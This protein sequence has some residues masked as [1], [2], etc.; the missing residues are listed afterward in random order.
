MTETRTP[1]TEVLIAREEHA[2]ILAGFFRS[3]WDPR[4]TAKGVLASRE[5][6]AR[7]NPAARGVPPPTFLVVAEGKCIGFVTTIPGMIWA[8]G[9]EVQ[10]YWLKGL[11]VLPEFRNGPVGFLLLKEAVRH[12][13]GYLFGMA[14][15][16]AARKL[17][18]ALKFT[19]LGAVPNRLVPLAPATIA[20]RLDLGAL[21][22]S[23]LPGWVSPLVRFGRRAGLDRL[24]GAMLG[25]VRDGYAGLASRS[26]RTLMAHT[27]QAWNEEEVS[28]I[29]S[30]MREGMTAG[31]VRNGGYFRWRFAGTDAESYET[32]TVRKSGELLSIAAIK[33]PRD[34]ADPRL[35][36][37]RVATLSD[38]VYDPADQ[39]AGLAALIGA[40]QV[41]KEMG[42]HALLAGATGQ[43]L[44]GLLRRRG[45]AS[46]PGNVH[47]LVR[48]PGVPAPVPSLDKW[49][50]TR[51]DGESD[52]F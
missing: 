37:I 21:N 50:V 14:V 52:G 34:E 38:L 16:P 44:L 23:G 33:R 41:A 2:E 35:R 31:A 15:A 36:G 19:D 8:E 12:L 47:C 42:A 10:G 6:E 32:V 11:M 46:I 39:P 29:W 9:K 49:W 27:R 17:F 20:R 45:Y 13:D 5:R 24:G 22:I 30:R 18:Q 28:R 1:R 7:E 43:S 3:V 48:A 26:A 51:G 4:A 25:L 40:E